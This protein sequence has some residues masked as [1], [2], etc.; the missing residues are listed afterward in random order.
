MKKLLPL[1]FVFVLC[2]TLLANI[3]RI[4]GQ[5]TSDSPFLISSIDDIID[6]QNSYFQ[7]AQDMHYLQVQDFAIDPS[8]SYL[9][10]NP[11][12]G[13]S[14]NF[15]GVYDG[16][17]YNIDFQNINGWTSLF[18]TTS[19]AHLMNINLVNI[20]YEA[21]SYQSPFVNNA[22]QTLFENCSVTGTINL[23]GDA[24]G[25]VNINQGSTISNCFVNIA[26]VGGPY[27]DAY[28][29]AGICCSGFNTNISNCFVVGEMHN[30]NGSGIIDT[31]TEGI[32]PGETNLH[33]NYV[34][35]DNV[36]SSVSAMIGG[37]WD[38]SG[39]NISN[40]VWNSELNTTNQSQFNLN[41][42]SSELLASNNAD[43]R[44]AS[45]FTSIGWDFVGEIVNGSDDYWSI[46]PQY[47]NGFPYL[48]AFNPFITDFEADS[49]SVFVDS[50]VQ[51]TDLSVGGASNWSWD[52]DNDGVI[53]SE[54]Q[55][56]TYS[57]SFPGT[58]SVNLTT[59]S[60]DDSL[61]LVKTDYIAVNPLPQPDQY[62]A[63]ES[64]DFGSVFDSQ[65]N[66]LSIL[67]QNIGGVELVVNSIE[68]TDPA[69]SAS[70][71]QMGIP[72]NV[73]TGSSQDVEI[74]FQPTT[75]GVV[76]ATL[77]I[78]TND[79]IN[80]NH[81]IQLTG[82]GHDLVA[83]FQ[84]DPQSGDVPLSVQFAN[85]S[86]GTIISYLWDFGDGTTST[87][88]FGFHEYQVPGTYSVSL[89]VFDANHQVTHIE[90][91]YIVV[92]DYANISTNLLTID[93]GTIYLSSASRDTTVI[94]TNTGVS[95]LQVTDVTI[96]YIMGNNGFTFDY[97]NMYETIIE[98][99]TSNMQITFSP[100][101]VGEYQSEIVLTNNSNASP[102][103]SISLT[104][105]CE[106]NPP[107]NPQ[108]VQITTSGN[109]AI[110]SWDNVTED[111]FNNP[112]TPNGYIVLYNE[113]AS[114][115][116]DDYYFLHYVS[117]DSVFTHQN[118]GYFRDQ[119]YYR[120]EAYI[121]YSPLRT[122][123]LN[124]LNSTNKIIM[125]KDIDTY[126]EKRK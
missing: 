124:D 114:T 3:T 59:T 72:F 27:A 23:S 116:N 22:I 96:N 53:D 85:Y 123:V 29:V 57:Y 122:N 26:F 35:I 16:G 51:F 12:F 126:I 84:G 69:Y 15:A 50:Q 65:S 40:N 92:N 86:T 74:T 118:V 39:L 105:I 97:P 4:Q 77:T 17:N 95:G 106:Y 6:I 30:T 11:L 58:Y 101:N 61:S 32:T 21:I 99:A 119:M 33:N 37:I 104:G 111:I 46:S 102:T 110:I 63:T 5:G 44:L 60:S 91:D 80:P 20:N 83:D 47:N 31:I 1:L 115:D 94:I 52:F 100:D 70:V 28:N 8:A 117:S 45:T 41:F 7:F 112:I 79:P 64:L 10:N 62:C 81:T 88:E 82:I 25:I 107:K 73:S 24:G 54:L 109:D 9:A 71:S 18:G 2:N 103:H 68:S 93:F 113:S 56:P 125:Y 42:S 90:T 98:N 87:D 121:S 38:N 55:N 49:T 36:N 34:C 66:T 48:T 120:V 13:H 75:N 76:S 108:N 19:G 89:T 78:N 43:M 14:N 67:I